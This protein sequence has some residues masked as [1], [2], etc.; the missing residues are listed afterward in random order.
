MNDIPSLEQWQLLAAVVDEGGFAQAADKLCKSQSAVSYGIKQLQAQVGVPLLA[1]QGR[2]A[3]LTTEGELLLKRARALLQ[4]AQDLQRFAKRIDSHQSRLLL[5]V[6]SLLPDSVLNSA[7]AELLEHY[8]DLQLGIESTVLS[9]GIESLLSRRVDMAVVADIPPG[10]LGSAF[11]TVPLVPV[12]SPTH[13]LARSSAKQP[14]GLSELV[15]ERQ[16]VI[17]DSGIKMERDAGWLGA[18]RRITVANLAASKQLVSAGL[19]FAW[20]PLYAIAQ[21]LERGELQLLN[22]VAA[23]TRRVTLYI[24]HTEPEA[25]TPAQQLMADALMRH[26][27]R[28]DEQ[29]WLTASQ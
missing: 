29:R 17:R 15:R 13:P 12:V 18:E 3:V 23:A 2:K 21:H 27:A 1:T 24:V 8:P 16:I 6:E 9:G 7:L 25:V 20:L 11:C 22:L 14:I 5:A 26:A 19:G 28:L 4:Q 10:F